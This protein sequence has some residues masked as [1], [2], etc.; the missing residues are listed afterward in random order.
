MMKLV[1]LSALLALVSCQTSL[2]MAVDAAFNAVSEE[3]SYDAIMAALGPSYRASDLCRG[4]AAAWPFPKVTA[5]SDLEAALKRGVFRCAFNTGFFSAS[6]NNG[7]TVLD[8]RGPIATG[9]LVDLYAAIGAKIAEHYEQDF[10]VTWTTKY[11]LSDDTLKAVREGEFD[12]A[13]A[14]YTIGSTFGQPPIARAVAFSAGHCSSFFQDVPVWA[15][16][17]LDTTDGW[18]AVVAAVGGGATFCVPGSVGG[19]S[20]QSCTRSLSLFL[21]GA[22]CQGVGPEAFEKALNG[23]GCDFVYGSAATAE[24]KQ[25]AIAPLPATS[26]SFF[27]RADLPE[28]A[29]FQ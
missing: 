20:E 12:A 28:D 2:Q 1:V 7:E 11:E 29:Y 9:V 27:R 10:A 25:V 3:G 18:E 14:D 16:P 5:G 23:D 19:G 24:F 21:P 8:T 13:C 17:R 22:A 26:G 15:P 4:P 6:S